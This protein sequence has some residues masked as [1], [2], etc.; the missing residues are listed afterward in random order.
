MDADDENRLSE[1]AC[2]F[3]GAIWPDGQPYDYWM[4]AL[5][6]AFAHG[7]RAGMTEAAGICKEKFGGWFKHE[8]APMCA[9]AILAYLDSLSDTCVCVEWPAELTRE[10]LEKL[11][12]S[13][14]S[15][16]GVGDA[17]SALRALAAIAPVRKKRV[18]N[19]WQHVADDLPVCRHPK[20]QPDPALACNWTLIKRNVE[21]ED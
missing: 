1:I 7:R 9:A 8:T 18:V 19:L 12:S 16:Y 13:W 11:A 6:E 2:R 4:S 5:R 21:L 20:W 10:R 14:Q 3:S 15:A 17:V